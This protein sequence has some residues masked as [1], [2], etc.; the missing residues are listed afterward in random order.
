MIGF[1]VNPIAGMGGKVGLK[2]TDGVAD[3]ARKMGGEPLSPDKAREFLEALECRLEFITVTGDMGENYLREAGLEYGVIYE[4]ETE[5]S[6][7]DTVNACASMMRE[8]ADII[9]FVGGDGTA[10]DVVSVTDKHIPIL[11]IPSGVKMYSSCFSLTPA[12]GGKI[13]CDFIEESCELREAEILDIDEELYR[14][15]ILAVKLYGY[16][17]VPHVPELIQSSKMERFEGNEEGAKEDIAEYLAENMEDGVLYLMGAGTTTA[18]IA[19][20]MG[21]EKTILGVDAYH[22]GKLVGKDLNEEEILNLIKK[23][24]KTKIIVSPIGSQGFIFGRGNPQI[25]S[26]IIKMVGKD[27]IIVVAT[28]QK[29][30]KTPVLHVYTGDSALDSEFKGYIRVITG[31]G[32]DR[33]KRIV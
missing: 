7:E 14:D 3:R 15:G 23:Y 22:N 16:A 6:A 20:K 10:R 19:E 18:K 5:T 28:P 32:R 29:M 9:V 17:L 11:G 33:I 4:A 24:R 31:Y 21:C 27:N 8:G 1:L 25:S 2:G 30:D 13:L 26:E 12:D